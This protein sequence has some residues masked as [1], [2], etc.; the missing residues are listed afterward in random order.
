MTAPVFRSGWSRERLA[1]RCSG[2]FDRLL[3]VDLGRSRLDP[4]GQLFSNR[5]TTEANGG[6]FASERDCHVSCVLLTRFIVVRKNQNIL[7][8]EALKNQRE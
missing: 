3:D 2:R 1:R 6:S 7:P 4:V 8:R 5:H